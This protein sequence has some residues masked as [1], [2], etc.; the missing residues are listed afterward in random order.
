MSHDF[1]TGLPSEPRA[2]ALG[3]LPH[4]QRHLGAP[5]PGGRGGG[6]PFRQVLQQQHQRQQG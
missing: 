4:L 5:Q 2:T 1:R 6:R 3:R